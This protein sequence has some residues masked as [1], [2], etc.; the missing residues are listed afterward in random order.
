MDG[1]QG[2]GAGALLGLRGAA[3]VAAFG[4][5]EDAAG[6]YDEDVAVGELLF[7][8]AGEAWVC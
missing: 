2:A 5:G 1:G 6:G 8:L 4:A 7:K 3:A